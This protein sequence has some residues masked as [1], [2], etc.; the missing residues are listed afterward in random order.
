MTGGFR[1]SSP[2]LDPAAAFARLASIDF[3][4]TGRDDVLS[5][6]VTL[7]RGAVREAGEVSITLVRQGRAMTAAFTGDLA[8]ALDE[9]QYERGYGPCLDACDSG[10]VLVVTDTATE[11]RW[12]AFTRR[13]LSLGVHSSLSVPL[14]VRDAAT[15]AMNFYAGTAG[16]FSGTAARTATAFAGYAAV[17]VANASSYENAAAAAGRMRDAARTRSLIDQAKGILVARH[18]IGGEDALTVLILAARQSDRRLAQ[19]A[20]ALVNAAHTDASGS[21]EVDLHAVADAVRHAG[22]PGERRGED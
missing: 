14:P 1:V 15:G 16:A 21:G 9:Q 22:D 20:A 13:A 7:A 11:E 18:R 19:V 10:E 12:P 5:T 2:S 4:R 17:A 8:V 6:I 3:S